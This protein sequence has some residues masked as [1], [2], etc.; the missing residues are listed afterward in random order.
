[1]SCF[2]LILISNDLYLD[3]LK[4]NEV[5]PTFK[6]QETEEEEEGATNVEI[7]VSNNC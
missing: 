6:L 1:M 7:R 5:I 2:L 3:C 4:K